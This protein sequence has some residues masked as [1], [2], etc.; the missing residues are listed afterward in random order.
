MVIAIIFPKP[1]KWTDLS[2]IPA[3]GLIVLN[4]VWVALCFGILATRYRDISPLL[5]SL[6]QLLFFM[7]PIIWN[8]ATLQ[9]Q[10]AGTW[11]KIVEL[12]PLL[13][14]L[15]IVR[16]PLLGADQELR[17]W[18][19]VLALTVDR[20]DRRRVRDAPVPR[21]GAVLGV[22]RRARA[23]GQSAA[24]QRRRRD[25]HEAQLL[26]GDPR[27]QTRG[28]GALG[29][30]W[31]FMTAPNNLLPSAVRKRTLRFCTTKSTRKNSVYP[32]VVVISL[33]SETP[34][35]SGQ[36][37]S[38]LRLT[39]G[40]VALEG[41]TVLGTGDK[42]PLGFGVSTVVFLSTGWVSAG[43]VSSWGAFRFVRM[44]DELV[45]AAAV[46]GAG[47]VGGWARVENA[48]CA[49]KLAAM[50]EVLQRRLAADGSAER[51]QWCLDNWDAVCAE[52]GAAF[53]VSLGVASHQLTLAE[54]LRERLPRVGEVFAAGLISA[55]L[56]NT[57]VYRTALITD[58]DARGKVDIEL[59]AQVVGWGPLSVAKTELAVDE[60][61]DRHD[62]WALRRWESRARGRHFDVV[63]GAG[64]GT[65]G[66]EGVLFA[67]DAAVLDQRLDAM[68][69]AVCAADPRTCAQ[70]RADA[71]GALGRGEDWLACRCGTTE[72]PAAADHRGP[73][74]AVVV[75]VIA[76][77][78]SLTE[79]TPAVLDGAAEPDD[80]E[81]ATPLREQTIAEALAPPAPP[82]PTGT[83]TT[84]PAVI[85]GGGLLPAP[86]LA[87][88]LAGLATLRPLIHPVRRGAR[89][90][91]H[92]VA[93]SG[94]FRAVPRYDMPVP[95]L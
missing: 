69:A 76:E 19:V 79:D 36:Q 27:V 47:A 3:L 37:S 73:S 21:A 41:R 11:A 82:A 60:L 72:C 23:R 77:A 5:F 30:T 46:S 29:R 94:R 12:N 52:I 48:A 26:G 33:P 40:A 49:R 35:M 56:V 32:P 53:N 22:V 62:P 7:T 78:D 65:A 86:L 87:A 57:I 2:F 14:Y 66:V 34:D 9:Q 24:G 18:V 74:G 50:A 81:A 55:R 43:V 80:E 25:A 64:A 6:V 16:A 63:A 10:G 59:A 45:A 83:A 85:V 8:E 67:H 95:G 31:L 93:G 68:A 13:H 61:V 51:E 1:W 44:F 91:L 54:A 75:H 71:M 92:P 38:S 42:R 15:D 70:R 88:K 20:L 84:N 58:P 17:H 90:A 39:R 28:F 4:C 89:T